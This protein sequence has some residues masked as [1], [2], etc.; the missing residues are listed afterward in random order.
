MESHLGGKGTSFDVLLLGIFS[1]LE[2]E[3]KRSGS[4]PEFAER[5]IFYYPSYFAVKKG[6]FTAS[7]DAW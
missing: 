1:V 3:Q 7:V 2:T 6:K 4:L 5:N